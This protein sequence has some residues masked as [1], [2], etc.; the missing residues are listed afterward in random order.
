MKKQNETSQ[1]TQKHILQKTA[2]RSINKESLTITHPDKIMIPPYL[3]KGDIVNYYTHIAPFMVPYMKNHP[4]MMH[5]FPE[6]IT[7]TSFF[8]KNAPSSLPSWI[9]TAYIPTQEGHNT[10]IVCQNKKTLV[11]LA[12]LNCLTPHLWLSRI[13]SLHF[14]DRLIFDLDPSDNS[15]SKVRTV[16]LLLKELLD[17]LRL[18]SFVMTTGSRGLHVIVPL[19]RKADFTTVKSLA[20]ACASQVKRYHPDIVTLEVKIKKRTNKVFI[21]TARNNY[22]ATAVSPYALRAF[23]KGPLATPLYWSELQE[24]SIKDAQFCTIETIFK[25][26]EEIED[27]WKNFRRIRQGVASFTEKKIASI[28]L[29]GKYLP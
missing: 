20:L 26:I 25:R 7:G 27:P 21:D 5:R 16:A 12:N 14:P 10:F 8:Q 22:A 17:S 18:I 24:N 19:D 1:T 13:D 29:A 3:T 6:G 11:Y 2:S 4:V 23:S 15:F 9:H 28:E